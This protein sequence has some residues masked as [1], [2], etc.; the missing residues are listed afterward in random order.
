LTDL[1]PIRLKHEVTWPPA[2]GI[3]QKFYHLAGTSEFLLVD[4]AVV[5]ATAPDKFL[6]R[7]IHGEA[8]VFFDKD[9]TVRPPPLDAEKFVHGL[10]ERRVR[11]RE[12]MDLF[13][14]FVLKE[15]YRKNWLEALEFYRGLVLLSLVEALRMRHGPEHYDFRMRYVYRELPQAIVRRLEELAFVRD[16]DD[17][18]AKYLKALEWFREA[19]DSIDEKRLRRQVSGG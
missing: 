1:A 16:P 7:E 15:I 6:V 9:G 13:G 11:L 2:S 14:P 3:Y 4:L 5:T 8:V 19:I 18:A 12:R 17:L 10:L